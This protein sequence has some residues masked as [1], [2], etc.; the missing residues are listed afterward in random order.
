MHFPYLVHTGRTRLITTTTF[1]AAVVNIVANYV[2]IDLY[3]T[4]GAAYATVLAYML[5]AILITIFARRVMEM[6][7]RMGLQDIW[8]ALRR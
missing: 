5:S 1:V 7:W 3:G 2:L 8:L 6:P 4:I